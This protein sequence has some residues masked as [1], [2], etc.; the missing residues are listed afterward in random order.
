MLTEFRLSGCSEVFLRLVASQA[1]DYLEHRS[2][3]RLLLHW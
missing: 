1:A 2:H 3:D